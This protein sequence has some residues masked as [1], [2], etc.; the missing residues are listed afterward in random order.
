MAAC[1]KC[2]RDA[3]L[4]VMLSGGSQVERYQQLLKERENNP[5]TPEEQQGVESKLGETK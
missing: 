5:C 4:Q 3:A 1:E 2:W